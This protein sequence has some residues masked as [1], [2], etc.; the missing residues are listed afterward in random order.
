MAVNTKVNN[1]IP[2][3]KNTKKHPGR[4]KDEKVLGP[5]KSSN[6]SGLFLPGSSLWKSGG[7]SGG[8]TYHC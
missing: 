7:V 5:T 2:S 3:L 8:K 1:K 4:C 6:P